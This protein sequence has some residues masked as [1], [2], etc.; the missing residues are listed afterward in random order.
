MSSVLGSESE[1]VTFAVESAVVP[2][3]TDAL[4]AETVGTCDRNENVSTGPAR[5][6]GH[7]VWCSEDVSS[8]RTY[9]V[10]CPARLGSASEADHVPLLE[11]TMRVGDANV[12]SSIDRSTT[13]SGA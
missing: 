10:W 5:T 9:T 3:V 1:T 4:A 13:P 8:C 6:S 12:E 2:S 11:G 7:A